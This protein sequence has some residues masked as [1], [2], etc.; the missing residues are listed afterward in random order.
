M[1]TI[2]VIVPVYKAE[3]TLVRCVNSILAQ[4]YND[5]ELILIDD[6]SPDNCGNIC[7]F[8]ARKDSRVLVLH[9]K[10]AGAASARNV[11]IQI[12][13]GKYL[14]FCDSDDTVSEHWLGRLMKYT[15]EETLAIGAYCTKSE[16][17][18]QKCILGIE[19]EVKMS[20]EAYYKFNQTGVAGYLWNALYCRKVVIEND[21][22]LRER[23]EAGDYNE[24]LKFAI[25][26]VSKIKSLVYTGY[27]DYLYNVHE[28]SLSKSYPQFY[29]EKYEEKYRLWLEFINEY[30]L[31]V[32]T[33]IRDLSTRYLFYFLTAM[34]NVV[35]KK[36]YIQFQKIVLSETVQNC[37]K[38][39]D[40]SAENQFVIHCI[41]KR[42]VIL[43]WLFLLL[44]KMKRR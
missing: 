11:G 38:K 5:F 42:A 39:A 13:N 8:F 27:A 19:P 1:P 2:S 41:L 43:L 20:F 28:G 14:A 35:G 16:L 40:A 29:Y 21:I 22:W 34:Q 12:A 23:R 15:N 44:D 32:E 6:G 18:S 4:S 30:S 3:K 26:Y 7:E 9:Q 24:D 31:D 33:E 10:N 17:L 37:I 25:Q 36:N